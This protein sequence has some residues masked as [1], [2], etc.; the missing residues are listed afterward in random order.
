MPM[1]M[2]AKDVQQKMANFLRNWLLLRMTRIKDLEV[3]K[4]KL[5]QIADGQPVSPL[6]NDIVQQN[7]VAQITGQDVDQLIN[8]QLQR[9]SGIP[10]D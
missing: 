5:F 7:Q 10:R 4:N 8:N 6:S 1:E 2:R 9:I 3:Q